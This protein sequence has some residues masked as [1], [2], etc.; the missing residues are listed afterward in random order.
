MQTYTL[1]NDIN[2][3]LGPNWI[4]GLGHLPSELNPI[5]FLAIKHNLTT[6]S[7]NDQD[8]VSFDDLGKIDITENLEK[9]TTAWEKFLALAGLLFAACN[10]S[11]IDLYI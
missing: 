2:V 9:I 7:S 1:S 3:E 6:T 10:S 4:H 11:C 5:Y 8:M